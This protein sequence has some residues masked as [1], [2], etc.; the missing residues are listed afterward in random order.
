MTHAQWDERVR[1]AENV[2]RQTG[3]KA[4]AAKAAKVSPLTLGTWFKWLVVINS[5]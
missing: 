1:R 3:S 4:K 5:Q 2:L